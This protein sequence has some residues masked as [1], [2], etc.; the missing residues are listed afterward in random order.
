MPVH[1]DEGVELGVLSE[2]MIEMQRGTVAYA[3]LKFEDKKL[4]A[5]P[6]SMLKIDLDEQTICANVQR[7]VFEHGRGMSL[8]QDGQAD[9]Q[10]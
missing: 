2:I 6:Y 4:F 8:K 5:L 7:E 10:T 9:R 3:V 1:N